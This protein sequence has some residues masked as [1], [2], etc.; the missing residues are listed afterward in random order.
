METVE[1]KKEKLLK[2]YN[3]T[4]KE[5]KNFLN[6][7]FDKEVFIPQKGTDRIKTFKDAYA[8]LPNLDGDIIKYDKLISAGISD[9]LLAYQ[10][11][12]IIIRVLNE[13]WTPDWDNSS[14]KKWYIW[15]DMRGVGVSYV[16]YGGAYTYSGVGAR[17][18][19]SSRELAE[20][21][22]KTFPEIWKEY[23][24]K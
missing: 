5:I 6:E 14:E 23:L 18:V 7:L 17:L 10:Q 21:C 22:A 8:A 13:G 3:N 4:T 16:G 19:F 15:W 12:V 2:A 9:H 24:K 20:F 1:I 11:L